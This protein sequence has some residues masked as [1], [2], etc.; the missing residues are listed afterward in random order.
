[1]NLSLLG[2]FKNIFSLK[3]SLKYNYFLYTSRDM[4]VF[5]VGINKNIFS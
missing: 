2:I 1:M 3:Y 4:N 5:L